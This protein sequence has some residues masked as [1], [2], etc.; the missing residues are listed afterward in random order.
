VSIR[1]HRADLE[2]RR[3]TLSPMQGAQSV[4]KGLKVV[5]GQEA[6]GQAGRGGPRRPGPHGVPASRRPGAQPGPRRPGAQASPKDGDRGETITA[7]EGE[8]ARVMK[9][10]D[11]IRSGVRY[12][13]L[14]IGALLLF[15]ACAAGPN[16][17]TSANP[18]AAGFWLGLWQGLISPITFVVSLF[19]ANVGIYE[20][21]N[22]GNWYDFGFML[23]VACAFSGGGGASGAAAGS[24]RKRTST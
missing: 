11:R 3:H 9:R 18:D 6:G 14:L 10:D 2:P 4:S 12:A 8:K 5:V 15:G 21:N 7:T 22:N 24:R 1:E 23:G 20:V 17:L 16:E 19:N 13:V